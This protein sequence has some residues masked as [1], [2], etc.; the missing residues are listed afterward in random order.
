MKLISTKQEQENYRYETV[1]AH[2]QTWCSLC[3]SEAASSALFAST[4][5]LSDYG[6]LN[7]S[8]SNGNVDFSIALLLHGV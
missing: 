3:R 1:Y 5:Q 4:K 7:M 2:T 6:K 8:I